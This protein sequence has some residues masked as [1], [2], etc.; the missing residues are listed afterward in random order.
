[1]ISSAKRACVVASIRFRVGLADLVSTFGAED[2][3]IV[4]DELRTGSLGRA[5]PVYDSGGHH[6][7]DVDR[8]IETLESTA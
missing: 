6:V 8:M 5:R 4:L 7:I 1:V 2:V 3:R